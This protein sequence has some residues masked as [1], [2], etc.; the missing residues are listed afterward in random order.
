MIDHVFSVVCNN[1]S[2][3]KDTN[4]VSIFNVMESVIAFTETIDPIILPLSF[5]ILSYWVSRDENTPCKGK[6]QAHYCDP[7]NVCIKLAELDINISEG[8]FHRTIIKSSG[9]Q[10][11]GPGRYKLQIRLQQEGSESWETVATLPIIVRYE[12]PP[13]REAPSGQPPLLVSKTE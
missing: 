9:L 5:E 6:M 13:N 8:L 11:K 4:T 3:D 2:I 1:L 10:V 7:D 12:L